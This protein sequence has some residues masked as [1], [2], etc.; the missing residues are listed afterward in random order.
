V[1]AFVAGN[2]VLDLAV[3]AIPPQSIIVPNE[4]RRWQRSA[5]V[6]A[7]NISMCVAREALVEYLILM[8]QKCRNSSAVRGNLLRRE[9][10]AWK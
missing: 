9:V 10:T 5:T 3:L 8:D 6:C 4:T 7:D 2:H 1:A